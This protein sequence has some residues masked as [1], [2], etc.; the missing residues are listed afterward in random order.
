MRHF[1]RHP[2]AFAQRGVRMN[3]LADIDRVSTHLD[4]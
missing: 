2:D 4:R 3:R 1:R